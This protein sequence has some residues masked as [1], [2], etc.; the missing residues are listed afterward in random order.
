MT[1]I[2]HSQLRRA[3][4]LYRQAK[5]ALDTIAEER[6]NLDPDTRYALDESRSALETFDYRLLQ[7]PAKPE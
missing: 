7:Q 4:T 2:S 5:A 1:P 3:R 6:L